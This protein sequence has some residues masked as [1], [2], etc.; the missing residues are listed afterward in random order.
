MIRLDKKGQVAKQ[1][2]ATG[3][4]YFKSPPHGSALSCLMRTV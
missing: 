2:S 3:F 4:F 1:E